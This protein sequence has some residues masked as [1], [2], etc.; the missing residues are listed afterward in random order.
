MSTDHDPNE[1]PSVLLVFAHPDDEAFGF[2][3]T[4]ARLRE[5]GTRAVLVCTTRGEVGEISSDRLA[6]PSTIGAVREMELRAAMAL[7]G[8]DDIRFLGY[9]DSGMDGTPENDDPRSFHKAP[10]EEVVAQLVAQIRAIRPVTV[11]TFGEDGIY[12]HPDHVAV[13]HAMAAAIPAAAD[14]DQ[15]IG[16]GVPYRVPVTYFAAVARERLQM[17]AQRADGPFRHMS[18]EALAKMG[19][20]EADITHK[21]DVSAYRTLKEEVI[22]AHATQ[23]GDDG[24][25]AGLPREQVE[26]FLSVENLVRAGDLSSASPDD[27]ADPI[28]RFAG[29]VVATT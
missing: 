18:Q 4:L 10:F 29:H 2:A 19:T 23:V 3:G 24:P 16:L 28:A 5:E 9:R 22:R 17:L 27:S 25:M 12:G 13:Y 14:P 11:I 7:V 15:P 6:T 1:T 20:P 8:V 21:I 26:A